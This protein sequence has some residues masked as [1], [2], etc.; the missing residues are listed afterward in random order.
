MTSVCHC[1]RMVLTVYALTLEILIR[2]IGVSLLVS[3]LYG[4]ILC[5]ET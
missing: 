2:D 3:G 5:S 4:I 1:Q